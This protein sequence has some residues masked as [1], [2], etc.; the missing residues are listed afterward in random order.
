MADRI[1]VLNRGGLVQ[2]GTPQEIYAAPDSLYVACRLGSPQINQLPMGALGIADGPAGTQ[3]IG[4][5]PEDILLGEG[6][7]PA[8]VLNVEPLGAET[9]ILL[10]SVGCRVHA[11]AGPGP[12]VEA[13]TETTIRALPGSALFFGADGRRLPWAHQAA[14]GHAGVLRHGT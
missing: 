8:H 7:A 13:H 6:G 5:R 2:V 3:T 4:V 12:A 11:L 10:E 1:G 14:S 9:V